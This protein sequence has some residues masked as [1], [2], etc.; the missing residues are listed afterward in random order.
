MTRQNRAIAGTVSWVDLSTPNLEEA[1]KFYSGLFGWTYARGDAELSDYTTAQLDGRRVAGMAS[2]MPNSPMPLNWT[3]YF[4]T[5]DADVTAQKVL[6]YQGTSAM[7]LMD[8]REQGRMG[9]FQDP[10]GAFFGI[11]QGKQHQGAE[12]IEEPGSMVWHEVY[13]RDV[14]RARDFYARVFGLET[15]KLDDSSLEYWTLHKGPK[16]VCG[17]MEMTSSVPPGE[18]PRWNTYFE[19]GDADAAGQKVTSLGGKVISP[20]FDTPWGRMLTVADPHGATFCLVKSAPPV[21]TSTRQVGSANS[22]RTTDEIASGV[23]TR[24]S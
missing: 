23:P 24:S 2:P 4:A 22:P 3:L 11:W 16:T 17:V 19:V 10:T 20:P 13:T 9:Y 12:T 6:E 5:D 7:P 1:K 15:K 8:I 18:P 14:Q 21:P